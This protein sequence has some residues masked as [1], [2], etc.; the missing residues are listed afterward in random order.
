MVTKPPQR[1]RLFRECPEKSNRDGY[2][3]KEIELCATPKE[4]EFDNLE[5][6]RKRED[7]IE[8]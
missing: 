7:L 2:W 6:R 4:I 5:E 8:L 1:H 3:T